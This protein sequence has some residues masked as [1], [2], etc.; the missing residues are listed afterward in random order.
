MDND[1]VFTVYALTLIAGVLSVIS[2][3]VMAGVATLPTPLNFVEHLALSFGFRAAY[4]SLAGPGWWQAPTQLS[5]VLPAMEPVEAL[6]EHAV[7]AK[8]A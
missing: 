5:E 1:K 2:A 6:P 8:A 3:S 7:T 4:K